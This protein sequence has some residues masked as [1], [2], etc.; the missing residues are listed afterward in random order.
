MLLSPEPLRVPRQQLAPLADTEVSCLQ[1]DLLRRVKGHLFL[2]AKAR[3]VVTIDLLCVPKDHIYLRA[4]FL[5]LVAA[6]GALRPRDPLVF[7]VMTKHHGRLLKLRLEQLHVAV[8]VLAL[9][10]ERCEDDVVLNDPLGRVTVVDERPRPHV[11]LAA[12]A[13]VKLITHFEDLLFRQIL[14]V[15]LVIDQISGSVGLVFEGSVSAETGIFDAF[16][17]KLATDRLGD[18]AVLE[19]VAARPKAVIQL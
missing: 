19:L 18:N 8:M 14:R 5:D 2:H 13:L 4:G 6:V 17:A 11:D 1:K 3:L 9:L 7:V 15:Q 10:G 16:W 12:D